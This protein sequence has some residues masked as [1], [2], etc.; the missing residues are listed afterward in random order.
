MKA[1][2][3]I[4]PRLQALEREILAGNYLVLDSFWKALEEEGTP[5][6]EAIEADENNVMVTFI[7]REKKLV[8][9]VVVY[10]AFPS[11]RYKENRMIR[12]LDTDIWFKTYKVRNDIRFRYNFSVNDSLDDGYRARAKNLQI[13]ELNPNR[14]VFDKDEEDE[15]SERSEH[16]MVSLPGVS[17]QVWIKPRKVVEEGSIELYKHRSRA[18]NNE[19]RV[20]IYKPYGYEKLEQPCKLALFFD[21]FDFISTLN[22]KTVLDNLMHERIIPPLLCAFIDNKDNRFEELTCNE[23][24]SGFVSEELLLWLQ[25]NFKVRKDPASTVVGGFSLGGL[26][27]AYIGMK[28]PHLFGNI[29]SQSGSFWWKEEW[30]INEYKALPHIPLKFYLNVGVLEDR[31]YDD[32]PVMMDSINRLRDV[33]SDKGYKVFYEQFQSGHDYLSWGDGL[34]NGLIKLFG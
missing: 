18:L 7:Y 20:W 28:Y 30:L 29:L 32:E 17:P 24:F 15:E 3:I 6:V 27:A 21:G 33:L 13:D 16:S 26:A 25:T 19:R 9:N 10:G 12:L 34:A 8:N 1:Q 4:S 23:G 11:Y 5:I 14:I 2:S 31:P 22:I